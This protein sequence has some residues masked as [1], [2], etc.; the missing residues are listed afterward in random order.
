[1]KTLLNL[2]STHLLFNTEKFWT[3]S[4]TLSLIV[5]NTTSEFLLLYSFIVLSLLAT[6][7]RNSI[8]KV[9]NLGVMSILVAG[10]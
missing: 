8:Y 6:F 5:I 4:E 2:N 7:F 10:L 9:L 3:I 1:M